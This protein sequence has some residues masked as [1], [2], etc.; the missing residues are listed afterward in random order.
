MGSVLFD[1]AINI[2]RSL[3]AVTAEKDGVLR[4]RFRGYQDGR[5][6]IATNLVNNASIYSAASEYNSLLDSQHHVQWR[7]TLY[8]IEL[9]QDI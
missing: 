2:I 8:I 1:A 6:D 3:I 7:V 9:Q 4:P 5:F